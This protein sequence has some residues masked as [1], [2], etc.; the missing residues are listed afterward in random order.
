MD[1][2]SDDGLLDVNESRRSAKHK[3][4]NERD[5]TGGL[6]A[7]GSIGT[8]GFRRLIATDPARSISKR[9]V[10]THDLAILT[11]DG[12]TC[13]RLLAGH[14]KNLCSAQRWGIPAS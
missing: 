9:F 6:K 12:I 10:T 7:R 3:Y 13:S 5:A 1:S 4:G 8:E 11:L 14:F 2:N